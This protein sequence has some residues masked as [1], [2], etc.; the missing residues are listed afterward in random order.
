MYQQAC[1]LIEADAILRGGRGG[2][3][4]AQG[5]GGGGQK[6]KSRLNHNLEFVVA[7]HM[8]CLHPVNRLLLKIKRTDGQPAE[9]R[10]GHD[11]LPKKPLPLP[12]PGRERKTGQGGRSKDGRGTLAWRKVHTGVCSKMPD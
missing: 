11:K 12:L 8:G 4:R 10:L 3:K 2:L 1:E 7:T 9:Q 6:K 5:T